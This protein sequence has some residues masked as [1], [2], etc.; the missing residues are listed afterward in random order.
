MSGPCL[1]CPRLC[2]ARRDLGETGFCGAGETPV[3]ARASLHEWEEPCIS[4][5]RGSGTVFFSG[6]CLR[7]AFCQNGGISR[8]VKGAALGPRQLADVFLSLQEKGAHNINLVTPTHFTPAV[9]AA[10]DD[11]RARGLTVPAVW[12][13]GGYELPGT[14]ERLRGRVS[15]FLPD[16][17]FMSPEISQRY[18]SAPDYAERAKAAIAKMADISPRP[19]FDA[20]GMVT[21]G[22]I[23]RVLLLPGCLSDAKKVIEY[24]HS[25]YGES[26]Y[27]SIMSQYTPF[28]DLERFPEL[29]RRV[30]AREYERLVDY[31]V[32]LG[33]VNGFT[34]DV[35]SSGLG[36]IPSFDCEGLPQAA[37]EA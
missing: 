20:D 30:R 33:V 27:I 26:V 16:F 12:N 23:V 17:K 19:V 29:K 25:E 9:A 21:S 34:Q 4:G 10:F 18:C 28:G 31:A 37:P 3:A 14:L 36:F 1:L 13:S 2:G 32:D 15:V 24:L 7:C 35:S 11:A 5:S 6:C 22:V 8:R